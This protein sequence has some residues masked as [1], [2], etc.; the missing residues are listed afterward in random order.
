MTLQL[1]LFLYGIF[2]DTV[3]YWAQCGM[4]DW[5]DKLFAGV[6]YHLYTR[7]HEEQLEDYQR[8]EMLRTR[9][10][11]VCLDVKV[12]IIDLVVLEWF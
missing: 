1:G 6:C 7:H 3:E 11:N 10:E 12:N 8:P 9:L 5:G 2:G 4:I